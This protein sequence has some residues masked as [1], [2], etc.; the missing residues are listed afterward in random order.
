MATPPRSAD[1]VA[2][3]TTQTERV[4]REAAAMCRRATGREDISD[5]LLATVFRALL[6]EADLLDDADDGWTAGDAVH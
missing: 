5:D 3:E 1:T 4:L 6:G 2:M